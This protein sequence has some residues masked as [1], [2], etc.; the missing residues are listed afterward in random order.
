MMDMHRSTMSSLENTKYIQQLDIAVKIVGE[1][2]A[3]DFV[4]LC[5]DRIQ[6][7]REREER[8]KAK[9]TAKTN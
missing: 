3:N 2:R 4:K 1:E 6:E 7:A 5:R 9:A 8:R